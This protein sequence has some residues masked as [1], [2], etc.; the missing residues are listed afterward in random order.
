MAPILTIAIPTYNR[1]KLLEVCLSQIFRQ[2][3]PGLDEIEVIV[4]DNHSM[5]GTQSV[6]QKFI[7]EGHKINYL[8]NDE[9]IGSDRNIYQCFKAASGKYVL[10][11]G[12]DDVLIDGSI[13]K[14]LKILRS[15]EYGVVNLA[16]YSYKEDFRS[17][18]PKRKTFFR[19]VEYRDAGSF[20]ERVNCMITFISGNVI[21]KSLVS[22]DIDFD[23][24]LKCQLMQTIWALSA[25]FNS[26]KN[27]VVDELMVAAKEAN[28]GGY[29]LANIFAVNQKMVFDLF[30]SRGISPKVF[31][32][33]NSKVLI[34]F[35]P[36]FIYL[37]RKT[38]DK[39]TFI[40]EDFFAVMR[41]L[42]SSYPNFWMFT[43]PIIKLPLKLAYV[44][45]QAA[46][47]ISRGLKVLGKAWII[48]VNFLRGNIS[49]TLTVGR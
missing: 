29:A 3:F 25:L 44:W 13:E 43:V 34:G 26:S 38:G 37:L 21:N 22:K 2:A 45:L 24:F 10:I 31:R 28:T 6:V 1:S 16:S 42:Y 8:R 40:K 14:L 35:F 32:R 36:Y 4:S 49:G 48:A 46:T 41:P 11:F 7:S 20:L 12:D 5:D 47:L 33:Y 27:L 9:N 39:S 17:E 18:M 15:G 23:S 19:L 30:V